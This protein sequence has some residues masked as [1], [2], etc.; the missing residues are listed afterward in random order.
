MQRKLLATAVGLV[1]AT[2]P[3]LPSVARA[4]CA[5]STDL[6]FSYPSAETAEVPLDA[7][8]WAV[9]QDGLGDASVRLDGVELQPLEGYGGRFQFAPS[10]PLSPGPHDIEISTFDTLLGRAVEGKT[11]RLRVEAVEQAPVD[12]E[13]SIEAV[14]HYPLPRDDGNVIY[15]EPSVVGEGCAAVTSLLGGC[16]D[17]IP[18]TLTRL[19]FS[20]RGDVIGYVVEGAILPPSCRAFFPYE[21][22]IGE[23]A[24]YEIR[25]ILPTG[26]SA[27]RAFQGEA[28]VVPTAA[29]ASAESAPMEPRVGNGVAT[30]SP[31]SC[32]MKAA[33]AGASSA[34]LTLLAAAGVFAS[35]R[36]R[37]E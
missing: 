18:E 24:P 7:V 22:T 21:Y 2:L 3:L 27:P 34:G 5:L 26:L 33:G 1:S 29:P 8:F 30:Q 20:A 37:R 35:R 32:A 10:E 16:N 19:D 28:E 31:E 17:I 6:A 14:T 23:A 4:D 15:P 9:T 11:L 13:A 25:T 12:A 36:R